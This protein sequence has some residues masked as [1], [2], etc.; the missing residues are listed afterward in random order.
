MTVVSLAERAGLWPA[1]AA[2]PQDWPEFMLHDPVANRCWARLPRRYPEWQL[3]VLDLTT[4]VARLHGVPFQWNGDPASL[5]ARGW[6]HLLEAAFDRP[7][8][9]DLTSGDWWLGLLEA[10]VATGRQG[11]GLG[12]LMLG[13]A[14][15]RAEAAG[16]AGT[17]TPARPTGFDARSGLSLAEYAARRR[18]DGLPVDAWLRTHRRAGAD[19]VGVCPLSMTIPGTLA[20][21]RAWTGLA[22]DASGDV[23][24]PGALSP[25]HVDL[26]NDHA[27]YVEPNVW[28]VRA[29]PG[30]LRPTNPSGQTIGLV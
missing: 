6:D 29:R 2:M 10:T 28:T 9:A 21:W 12:A 11:D 26:L 18:D 5:P 23:V 3:A 22:F 14:A 20:Q 16:L 25:V 13:A 17:L 27:V 15:E 1:L 30:S 8:P 24:V 19:I 4:V 7:V